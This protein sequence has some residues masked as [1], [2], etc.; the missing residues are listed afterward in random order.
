MDWEEIMKKK[1]II[2]I[3][4]IVVIGGFIAFR[5]TNKNKA[6]VIQ[7]KTAAVAQGEIKS[8]LS[9]TGTIKSKNSKDYFPLQGKVKKVNVKVGDIVKKDAVLV[10]YEV[11]DANV[12]VK[13]AQIQYDNA[14]LSKK[15][16][17]NSNSDMKN[18]MADMDKQIA[19]L[20][21][22]IASAKQ[23][24]QEA[25]KVP[26][27]ESQRAQLKQTRDS[28]KQPFSNEQLKQADNAIALAKI[29]LDNAKQNL[30]KSQD[31]IVAEADG[32]VTAVNV[33]EGGTSM[34]AAQAAVTVQDIDNLKAVVSVGKYDANKIQVGQEAIVKSGDKEYKA[35]VSMVDPAA[36]KTVS[37]TGSETTLG[38]EVDILDKPEGLKIDFDAD[39]DILLG[40][41]KDVVKVPAESVKTNKEDK[42]FVY[43]VD[44]NKAAQK[45]VKLGLQS[46]MESQVIEG[47]KAGDKVILNPGETVVNGILVKEAGDSK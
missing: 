1:I 4:I 44:G 33:I 45:E 17:T 30:S 9:T 7:V 19:D 43:I 47:V 2:W 11:S 32:V 29:T 13:Q 39:V 31:K 6:K 22:Q 36:K 41:I 40:Q 24:P 23:N 25:L 28:L 35:K 3:I 34:A 12:P 16:Q 18:K 38:I 15:M 27:L 46:D 42:A 10:E 21:N 37:A 8:Y 14:V 20:D 5:S 26:T